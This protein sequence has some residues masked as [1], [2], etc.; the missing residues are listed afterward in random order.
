MKIIVIGSEGQ[1]GKAIYNLAKTRYDKVI[2][3]DKTQDNTRTKNKEH[4]N[5]MHVCIP[6]SIDFEN[7]VKQYQ[8]QFKPE[9]TIIESTV[10]PGTTQKLGA[11]HSP[12][13]GK[14]PFL[15]PDIKRQ[16]KFVGADTP[17][18]AKKVM[19][20]YA[21]LG[22]RAHKAKNSRT[23]ETIKLLN[24]SYYGLMIAWWKE[25]LEYCEHHDA[26]YQDLKK[27]I[28]TTNQYNPRP[29]FT[30]PVN[31]FGGHC[32]WENAVMLNKTKKSKFLEGVIDV[33]KM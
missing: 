10:P 12:I 8:R 21:S 18:Q 28:E 24:T 23:T 33:G 13:R 14:H 26:D 32:V 16:V 11:V 1:T 4:T 25:M 19:E 7:I 2:G 9:I 15:L 31:G 29:I 6:Y 3:I 5:I 20:Y 22:L 17:Q 30:P 27:F